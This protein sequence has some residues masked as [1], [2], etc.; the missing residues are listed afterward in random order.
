VRAVSNVDGDMMQCL[1]ANKFIAGLLRDEAGGRRIYHS[2]LADYILR[3]M[4]DTEKKEYHKRAVDIYRGKLKK[5]KE[6]QVKPDELAAVRLPEHV[7]VVG[8]EKA[9]V[10]VFINECT[11]PLLNLGLLDEAIRLS[12]RALRMVKESS[13]NQSMILC[14]LGIICGMK[15]ELDKAAKMHIR[16]L[17]IDIIFRNLNGIAINCNELG[18]IYLTWGQLDKAEKILTKSTDI[19]ER[20]GFLKVQAAGYGNLGNIHVLKDELDKAEEMHKKSLEIDKKLGRLEGMASD[21]G[22]LGVVYG[23][24]GE[25]DREEEMQKRAL[26]INDRIGRS[27]G[28]AIQYS[29]L[30]SICEA[31]GDLGKAKDYYEKARDLY[32]K[33]GLIYEMKEVE[34]WMERLNKK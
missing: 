17:K 20:I 25:S 11:G 23:M 8:G 1:L 30:G 15:G 27:G 19:S 3:Q 16:A 22:N 5:A 32:K 33:M 9:F 31:R 21:Y 10:N 7:L 34:G 6:E 2:I 14:N 29:N 26:E 12:E 4:G 28:I 24:R 13:K 18:I